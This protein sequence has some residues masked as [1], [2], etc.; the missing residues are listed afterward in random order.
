MILPE[1]ESP[2]ATPGED[3]TRGRALSDDSSVVGPFQTVDRVGEHPACAVNSS[4]ELLKP[5]RR[6]T[7]H[8][9]LSPTSDDEDVKV[10][11]E[12]GV[13]PPLLTAMYSADVSNVT[14]SKGEKHAFVSGLSIMNE[15]DHVLTAL[16]SITHLGTQSTWL[17]SQRVG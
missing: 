10:T 11:Y 3:S 8:V 7:Q 6:S 17:L 5:I 2:N 15:Q 1:R 4:Q 16:V 12:P 14:M 13:G 9:P